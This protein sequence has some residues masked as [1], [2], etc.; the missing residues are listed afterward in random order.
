[1]DS[2]ATRVCS[3]FKKKRVN[4]IVYTFGCPFAVR[5]TFLQNFFQKNSSSLRANNDLVL[6]IQHSQ[7]KLANINIHKRVRAYRLN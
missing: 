5:H 7:R 3:T 4:S 6:A 2:A 1:M